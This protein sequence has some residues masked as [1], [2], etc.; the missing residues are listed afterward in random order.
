M[1]KT[2]KLYIPEWLTTENLALMGYKKTFHP[3]EEKGYFRYES[4]WSLALHREGRE[5]EQMLGNGKRVVYFNCTY[6]VKDDVIF[7][8]IKEDA[9]TRTV[10]HGVVATEE[11]FKW[12]L[13]MVE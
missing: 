5:C 11:E 10:F 13:K 3:D 4:T 7:C 6:G 1:V 9:G 8:S 12:L 2:D